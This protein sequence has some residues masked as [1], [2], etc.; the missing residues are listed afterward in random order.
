MRAFIEKNAICY[1][2]ASV[3]QEE[4]NRINILNASFKAMHLAIDKLKTKAKF[5]IIDGNRFTE[6]KRVPHQ[7][8]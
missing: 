2:V 4:T 6:Y 3:D 7:C 8:D 5:L 1:Q